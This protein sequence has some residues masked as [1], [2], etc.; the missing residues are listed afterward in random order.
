MECH[1]YIRLR[2]HY[3]AV[4]R[5]WGQVILSP[6]AESNSATARL[7]AEIKQRAFEER[8]AANERMYLTSRLARPVIPS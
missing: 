8:N 1:G 5:H 7:A 4:L 6:G 2:Q 3:E